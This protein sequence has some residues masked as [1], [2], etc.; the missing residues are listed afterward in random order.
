MF[1]NTLPRIVTMTCL[2]W[3]PC[4]QGCSKKDHIVA[5]EEKDI[6]AIIAVSKARADA[7]NQGNAAAIAVHFTEDALL[8]APDQPT[9]KG[10]TA[11][12]SYYQHIFDEYETRLRS[13]YEDVKVSGQIA[14]ERGFAE[15]ALIPKQ[16]GQAVTSTAKY[17]NIMKRGRRHVEDHARHLEWQRDDQQAITLISQILRI[18]CRLF[19]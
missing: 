16:G 10:K 4:L 7:F 3:L 6:A 18:R 17:I 11:V 19:R 14:Y 13:Y 5:S 15:V 1:L 8:M 2:L 12:Q 9:L